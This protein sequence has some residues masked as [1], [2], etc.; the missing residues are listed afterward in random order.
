M[1]VK[2]FVAFKP[3]KKDHWDHLASEFASALVGHPAGEDVAA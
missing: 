2:P 3:R 1:V